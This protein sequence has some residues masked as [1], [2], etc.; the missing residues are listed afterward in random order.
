MNFYLE[1]L[2]FDK[3]YI[4]EREI[5]NN[6]TKVYSTGKEA[7][8]ISRSDWAL[9]DICYLS[10][11]KHPNLISLLNYSFTENSHGDILL[12]YAMPLGQDIKLIY[13][14]QNE[15]FNFI[16]DIASALNYLSNLGYIYADLKP[17][18][19]VRFEATPNERAKYVL[20]DM[21]FVRPY[22]KTQEGKFFTGI[23]YTLPF[24]D[25]QFEKKYN[26]VSCE[27]YSFGQTIR[28]I[29]NNCEYIFDS[30][31]N[32]QEI[33]TNMNKNFP[34]ISTKIN[35]KKLFSLIDAMICKPSDR[36]SY[37]EILKHSLLENCTILTNK[38][39]ISTPK[40]IFKSKITINQHVWYTAVYNFCFELY[41]YFNLD[42]RGLFLTI[43]NVKRCL[44]LCNEKN[45]SAYF[46]VNAY[47]VS[48][49]LHNTKYEYVYLIDE[50]SNYFEND[51]QD[52]LIKIFNT[53]E[54][55]FVTKTE[56]DSCLNEKEILIS[57]AKNLTFDTIITRFSKQLMD[58]VQPKKKQL[59]LICSYE[60]FVSNLDI[61]ID[62]KNV[63][64]HIK[65]E[66]FKL[67]QNSNIWISK[68]NLLKE[69]ELK[70]LFKDSTSLE[71]CGILFY[72]DY[73]LLCNKD[74]GNFF[75]YNL[76]KYINGSS[77]KRYSYFININLL[78]QIFS[79][80]QITK[81]GEK[82]NL[83]LYL[84]NEDNSPIM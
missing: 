83:Y 65:N 15:L 44:H 80:N 4:K 72:W 42:I 82:T 62:F 74:L 2:I 8:K 70:S 7:I 66:S 13:S 30:T 19:I 39:Y 40:K 75:I 64:H 52:I 41:I 76:C 9:P 17:S 14:H 57:F 81:L 36:I 50:L 29:L 45:I 35:H 56:W 77:I 31:L 23:A 58:I 26:H 67:Q 37:T 46:I 68:T 21:G 60:K 3:E 27:I 79:Q 34:K 51:F 61:D 33:I 55:Q 63:V 71:N 11:F 18:N 49:I 12:K 24:R 25:F 20:I 78:K 16:F 47:I 38:N 53:L 28:S 59:S 73:E 32:E 10:Q 84:R 54:G 6:R 43:Y 22:I 48:T 69:S 1:S 5:I